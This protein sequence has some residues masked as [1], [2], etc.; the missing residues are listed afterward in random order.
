M[1]GVFGVPAGARTQ[2]VGVGGQY[3]IQLDYGY[4][5][6]SLFQKHILFYYFREDLA[7]VSACLFS[8]FFVF[9]SLFFDK[10]IV[11]VAFPYSTSAKR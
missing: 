11:C 4:V 3:F 2:N 9:C 6:F 5:S 8:P 7:S 1:R 10:K